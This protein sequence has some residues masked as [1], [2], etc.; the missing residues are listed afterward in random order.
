MGEIDDTY[1]G[2]IFCADCGEPCKMIEETFDYSGTHCTHGLSGTYHTGHYV[3]DCC[4]A[5]LLD[6]PKDYED[7]Q[8]RVGYSCGVMNCGNGLCVHKLTDEICPYCGM[9]MV[10]VTTTGFRFCSNHTL[11]CDYEYDPNDDD[12]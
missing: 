9:Q 3:S 7:N 8:C 1:G 10:E 2:L 5:E 4:C 11:A 12:A 6:E